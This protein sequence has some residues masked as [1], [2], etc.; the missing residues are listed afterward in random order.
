MRF[1]GTRDSE[2][3]RLTAGRGFFA[4]AAVPLVALVVG[5]FVF[6]VV[7]TQKTQKVEPSGPNGL[8]ASIARTAQVGVRGVDAQVLHDAVD[9]LPQHKQPSIPTGTPVK[10]GPLVIDAVAQQWVWRF[11]YPGG[12]SNSG[13]YDPTG[14]RPGDRLYSVG[15]LVVPVDTTVL[16]NITSTDVMHRWFT[17]ALGGQV[18][19]VPGHVSQTWFRADEVGVY[20]GQSTAF[21]GSGYSAMRSWVRVVSVPAYQQFLEQQSR[22]LASAQA[23]VD[24]AVSTGNVPGATP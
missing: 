4:R 22:D 16:L 24:H 9:Q 1:R 12:L 7:M 6:G 8:S 15:E 3:A 11:F 5:L 23:Y 17:P 20:N 14:G 19:A 10:G 18:D 2:P 13:S 21:S